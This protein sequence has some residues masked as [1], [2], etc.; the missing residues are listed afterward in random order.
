MDSGNIATFKE[1]THM[2]KGFDALVEIPNYGLIRPTLYELTSTPT[3]AGFLI[4]SELF[5]SYIK[6]HADK[7]TAHTIWNTSANSYPERFRIWIKT[8]KMLH[9]ALEQN[10]NLTGPNLRKFILCSYD[11]YIHYP[12]HDSYNL[13]GALINTISLI[14][15]K[16]NMPQY[17]IK[18]T[19]D[20]QSRYMHEFRVWSH[21]IRDRKIKDLAGN[22][23]E[24]W[25][26]TIA[27]MPSAGSDTAIKA[28]DPQTNP[29]KEYGIIDTIEL[30]YMVQQLS[31]TNQQS[32]F[33]WKE[34]KTE[35]LSG[36]I[37]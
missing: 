25:G 8:I 29:E 17:N 36:K 7:V 28:R 4:L 12:S 13:T 21:G 26:T 5:Y 30:W 15:R 34:F 14:K 10:Q 22:P 16:Q 31:K 19:Q 23:A 1:I 24:R 27:S 3:G 37:A 20:N 9:N 18:A 35:Y 33:Q 6:N 2:T 32:Q 11:L